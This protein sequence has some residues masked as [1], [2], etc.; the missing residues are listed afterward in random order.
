M[1]SEINVTPLVD[2]MLVLLIIF[3][4]AAPTMTQ[5]LDVNLPKVDTAAL[6]T[7][8]EQTILT[9]KENGALFLDELQVPGDNLAYQVAEVMKTKGN[10][11]IF[12]RADQAT[13]YGQVAKVM[14]QLRKAGITNVGLVTEPA[15]RS[16]PAPQ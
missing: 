1:M 15:D 9:I 3:M 7:E 2:V 6:Q 16:I 13:P 8:E 11:T 14:G 10:A 4:V 12:I 5:G